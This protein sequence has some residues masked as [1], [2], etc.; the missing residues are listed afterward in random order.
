MSRRIRTYA[1]LTGADRSDLPGQ[2]AAQ[3]ER[4]ARRLARVRHVVG[5]MSGKGGVGK[6]FTTALLAAAAS[7]R[8]VRTAVLDAD[9]AG[10]TVR[11]LLGAPR[12]SLAV[13]EGAVRPVESPSGVAL[14]STDLL[15]PEGAPLEWS[16]SG[17]ESFV[18]RGAQERAALRELLSDVAWGPRDLLLVDLPPGVGRLLDLAE[19]VP[20][21]SAVAVTVPSAASRASVE[22][23]MAQCAGR[24]VRLLG[25]VENMAGY[26]CPEC[27]APGP[28]FEGKAGSE[29]AGA[30]DVPLLGRV[31]FDPAAG[32]LAERGEL[33]AALRRSPAGEALAG[34]AG[35]L[36]E[37]LESPAAGR[38]GETAATG[39]AGSAGPAPGGGE[40]SAGSPRGGEGSP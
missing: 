38:G 8:G 28:L 9:L 26:A 11:L 34:I 3:A 35:V 21:L 40:G 5:V 10:P 15:L 2:L 30:F 22:R 7:R 37:A 17:S 19:L 32:R 6:S 18:W 14:M 13:E 4:V 36:L 12:P 24:G 39:G 23:A 31:P 29:L 1:E 27:G 33:R 20:G 16:G 25:V